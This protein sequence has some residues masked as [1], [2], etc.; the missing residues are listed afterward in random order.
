MIITFLICRYF[1]FNKKQKISF[2]VNPLKAF[3][4]LS[5]FYL[6]KKIR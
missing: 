3:T 6:L 1:L 5:K 4:G 2:A